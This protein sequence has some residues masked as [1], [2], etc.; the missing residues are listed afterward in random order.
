MEKPQ[1]ERTSRLR[2]EK[3]RAILDGA[4]HVFMRDGFGLAGIDD[5]VAEAGVSKRTLYAHFPSKEALFGAIVEEWCASLLTPLR[6]AGIRHRDTRET[7]VDLGRMFLDVILSPEGVQLYR[8]VIAEAPRF[9]DLGRV[10]YES[11]HQPAAQLLSSYL[12]TRIEAG[13]FREFDCRRAAEGFF[14]L[15]AG[16]SHERMLLNIDT[17]IDPEDIETYLSVAA[18]IF[19]RGIARPDTV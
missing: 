15:I 13:E 10:F 14:Q 2:P 1:P 12:R 8:V 5:I 3:R 19:L 9:P 18:E 7:L 6:E 17:Q 4:A 11:G 16:Y